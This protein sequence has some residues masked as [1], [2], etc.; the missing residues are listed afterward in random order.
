MWESGQFT[1][2]ER[3]VLLTHWCGKAWDKVSNMADF[4]EKSFK[5]AGC[6][7]T[8][9]MSELEAVPPQNIPGYSR[10]LAAELRK[11]QASE[12][13]DQGETEA[14]Q[15]PAPLLPSVEEEKCDSSDGGDNALDSDNEADE[16]SGSDD[17]DSATF[18]VPAGMSV[19]DPMPALDKT[20]VKTPIL[21]K[22][23]AR[24]W[25]LG[26]VKKKLPRNE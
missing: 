21:F 23:V 14:Q 24:G 15:V 16:V 19:Q 10:L 18:F 20:L 9:D 4:I 25:Q 1:A 13:T 3:R 11:V 26:R 2:S 8:A 7:L 22:W 5:G 12:A 6:L 17:E